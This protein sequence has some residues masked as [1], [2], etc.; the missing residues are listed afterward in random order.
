MILAVA[1]FMYLQTSNIFRNS[2]K[3]GVEEE[4]I[5]SRR[6]TKLL[7]I[8]YTPHTKTDFVN[9]LAEVRKNPEDLK[10][11]AKLLNLSEEQMQQLADQAYTELY[12]INF[13]SEMPIGKR[14]TLFGRRQGDEIFRFLQDEQ[15]F[16][17]MLENM[18]MIG[19]MRVPGGPDQLKDFLSGYTQYSKAV[20]EAFA[21]FNAFQ[22]KLLTADV[23]R[24]D[25]G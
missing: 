20:E 16:E 21:K 8:L 13:I 1:F 24:N 3:S 10:R 4:I 25:A 22:S 5:S 23:P 19:G 18:R 7:S 17:D 9:N 14:K 6:P 11:F 15:N 2:V 12:Y